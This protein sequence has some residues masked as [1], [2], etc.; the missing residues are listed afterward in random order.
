[1]LCG[2]N[3]NGVPERRRIDEEHGARAE[4]G[5]FPAKGAPILVEPLPVPAFPQPIWM[6]VGLLR[7]PQVK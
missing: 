2:K 4:V 6:S 7:V 1:M 5:A 3:W